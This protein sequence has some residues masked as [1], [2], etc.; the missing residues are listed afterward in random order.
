[1][2]ARPPL[3]VT[4]CVL[5]AAVLPV[6]GCGDSK[7][8]YCSKADQL[9]LAVKDLSEIDL[10]NGVTSVTSAASKLESSATAAVD[11]AKADF[12]NETGRIESSVSSLKTAV[13]Q[14][15]SSPSTSQ[16]AT[17]AL[18]IKS[19]VDAVDG[20]VSQTKKKCG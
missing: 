13:D 11:A 10:S 14:L 6:A 4:L 2:I 16:I 17:L 5:A 12:P 15:S 7:P 19:V 18:D 9:E 8:S 1:M 20:F 3:A